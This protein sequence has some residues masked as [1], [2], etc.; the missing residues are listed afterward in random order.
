MIPNQAHDEALARVLAV[1]RD[2]G[3][4]TARDIAAATDCSKPTA[5]AR[6]EALESRGD[7]KI[8]RTVKRQGKSGPQSIAFSLTEPAAES[9]AA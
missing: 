3:P 4:S 1:L 8:Y 5:Y 9:A 2:E 6:I 7:V